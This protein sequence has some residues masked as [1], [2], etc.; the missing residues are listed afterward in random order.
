MRYGLK[1]KYDGLAVFNPCNTCIN[2]DRWNGEEPYCA[3]CID[4][5]MY[6]GPHRKNGSIA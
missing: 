1:D 2:K 4:A 6:N 3:S 5:S